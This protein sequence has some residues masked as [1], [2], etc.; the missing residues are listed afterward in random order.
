MTRPK[1][2]I[3]ARDAKWEKVADVPKDLKWKPA[4]GYHNPGLTVLHS[5]GD[6]YRLVRI[7]DTGHVDYFRNKNVG[8]EKSLAEKIDAEAKKQLVRYHVGHLAWLIAE[9]TLWY[10]VRVVAVTESPDHMIVQSETGWDATRIEP[11]PYSELFEFP[12]PG[13]VYDRLRP[14]KAR[15]Q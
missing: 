6:F 2:E 4:V 3:A 15:Y 11:W 1:A 9:T 14:L 10:L 5:I 12:R 8:P 7:R 13:Q